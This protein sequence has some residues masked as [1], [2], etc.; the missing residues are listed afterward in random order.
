MDF[1][2]RA[3]A[4]PD[5]EIQLPQNNV[6]LSGSKST[7]DIG[8][9]AYKW[10]YSGCLDIKMTDE[11]TTNVKLSGLK[12]GLYEILLSVTDTAGQTSYDLVRVRVKP[13]QSQSKTGILSLTYI[14][15]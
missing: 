8:I 5:V 6:T 10:T 1:H 13:K 15:V 7:D 4:G 11:T 2:P 14:S 9:S 12:A 3:N